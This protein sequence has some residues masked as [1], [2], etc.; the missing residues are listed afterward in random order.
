MDGTLVRYA[1]AEFESS[2]GALAAAAGVAAASRA[3]VREFFP[4]RD[5]YAEWVR[6]D[7]ALLAGVVVSAVS[8]ELFPA[9]YARGVREAIDALRGR[10]SMGILSSGVDLV[11]NWIRDDLGL[12]FALA[13]A[14]RIDDG[15]FTG[16]GETRVALW[17]KGDV[18]ATLAAEQGFDLEETCYVGDHLNDIPAM[19]R[20]ALAIAANPKDDLVVDACA[21]TLDDLG[22]LPDLIRAYERG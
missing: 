5:A 14:L 18:L 2:W 6:R 10:C 16:E 17:Q 7:A 4:Q 3:L 8:R 13:N 15:R 1:G 20:V 21:H 12:D 19:E 22:R 11:A 9:P